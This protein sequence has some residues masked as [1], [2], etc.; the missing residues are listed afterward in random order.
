V[1]TEDPPKIEGAVDDPPRGWLWSNNSYK[2]WKSWTEQG[3]TEPSTK[4]WSWQEHKALSTWQ[5]DEPPQEAWYKHA[6]GTESTPAWWDPETDPGRIGADYANDLRQATENSLEEPEA[7]DPGESDDDDQRWPSAG[8]T[9]NRW[10]L[11][12]EKPDW[13]S[14][15]HGRTSSSNQATAE[16]PE[17]PSEEKSVPPQPDAEPPVAAAPKAKA[18]REQENWEGD[19]KPGES[20]HD[21]PC[22]TVAQSSAL[23]EKR[24]AREARDPTLQ[25]ARR[26]DWLLH[27]WGNFY[28][29]LCVKDGKVVFQYRAAFV[30]IKEL[31]D[32]IDLL[33]KTKA[34]VYLNQSASHRRTLNEIETFL[35][36]SAECADLRK[37]IR[38]QR[39]SLKTLS[40]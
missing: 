11:P 29:N 5:K 4:E 23:N 26:R 19:L 16:V 14:P 21:G 24:K 1:G 15:K 31:K 27:K 40:V 20:A 37:R 32:C 30:H 18:K 3:W 12:T 39:K 25:Q 34:E 33:L 17:D 6:C 28:K 13:T 10:W 22:L 2:D 38:G 36:T 35:E 8:I 7:I 9:R